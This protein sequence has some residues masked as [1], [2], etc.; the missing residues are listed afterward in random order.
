MYFSGQCCKYGS[1][2][3]LLWL[4]LHL[5]LQKA[6][7]IEAI[8]IVLLNLFHSVHMCYTCAHYMLQYTNMYLT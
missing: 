5:F 6:I 2:N 4:E 8:V 7:V 1:I 3:Q